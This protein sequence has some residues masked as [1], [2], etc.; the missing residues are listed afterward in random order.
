MAVI[1][2]ILSIGFVILL[3]LLILQRCETKRIIEQL[4]DIGKKETI[5][6]RKIMISNR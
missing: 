6:R 2:A 4:G 1:L 5:I 3:C